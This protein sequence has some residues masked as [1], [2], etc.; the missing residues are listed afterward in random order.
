MNIRLFSRLLI[1]FGFFL[2][3]ACASTGK[4]EEVNTED[5]HERFNRSMYG[6]NNGVDTYVSSPLVT[7]Y[8]WIIPEIT[9]DGTDVR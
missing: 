3:A 5:P 4:V 9:S 1:V 6:F 8:Q 7:A 2:L